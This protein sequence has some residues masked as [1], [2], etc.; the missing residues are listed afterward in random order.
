MENNIKKKQIRCIVSGGKTGGHLVPGI[1]IYEF[2]KEKEF[3]VKYILND[4]D[5]KFP[6][7]NR[8]AVEDRI[9]LS[10][11][12]IS[13]RFSLKTIFDVLKIFFAFIKIFGKILRFNPD[14]VVITGGY[15]SNPVALSTIIL[16]KKLYILEQNSVAGVTNRFYAHFAKKVFTSFE[17]TLKIPEKKAFYTGNPILFSEKPSLKESREFFKFP[18]DAKVVGII[19]GSQG[20]RV[21]NEVALKILPILKE[22]NIFVV[23]SV[24][25]IEYERLKLEKLEENVKIFP[26]IERMDYFY[27]AVDIVISRAGATS[28]S[29]ILYFK[30]PSIFIPIKK[31]PDNHQYINASKLVEKN[32]ALILEEDLLNENNLFLTVEKM[33]LNI[34]FYRN[35]FKNFPN[36]KRLPQEIICEEIEKTCYN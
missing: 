30:V 28:I 31:S 26:F 17:K 16:F 5:V 11:S 7:V 20:A 27:T 4:R 34:D 22:K 21:V 18:F 1:A 19:S 25:A 6:I 23:W 9:F 24:G 33:L 14:F 13:R 15:V 12:S 2:F 32:V 8:I 36:E 10:I 29:E 35:N 3:D